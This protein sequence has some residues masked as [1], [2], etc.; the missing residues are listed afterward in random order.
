MLDFR[1]KKNFLRKCKESKEMEF[2]CSGC[3]YRTDKKYNA[4]THINRKNKC[5][6]NPTIVEIPVI[7]ECKH[8]GKGYK[9][10]SNLKRHYKS[11]KIIKED[12]NERLRKELEEVQAKLESKRGK[13]VLENKENTIPIKFNFDESC[14]SYIYMIQE[15]EFVKSKEPVFKI[16]YTS[17]D[18]LTR[19]NGYP[20]GSKLHV[21][22]PVLGNPELN[23]I[24][25]FKLK[26]NHRTDLGNEYFEGNFESMIKTMLK[27]SW[28]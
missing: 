1:S 23:V 16:G 27:T 5:G 17:K 6:E 20:K 14:A 24:N 22:L 2:Q 21:C 15:R 12:E 13:I 19:S 26:Y 25:A 10:K 9:S 11:C 4:Y 18:I 3:D 8:C 7:I 28:K